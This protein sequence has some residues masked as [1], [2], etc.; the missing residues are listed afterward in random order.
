VGIGAAMKEQ[1]TEMKQ[2]THIDQPVGLQGLAYLVIIVIL[3]HAAA[4]LMNQPAAYWQ[5]PNYANDFPFSFLLHAG[6]LV[7]LILVFVYLLLIW[8]WLGR[9]NSVMALAAS[10][11]LL[12]IHLVGFSKVTM[13]GFYPIYEV[14]GTTGC[15]AFRYI[16]LVI[17]AIMLGLVLLGG[18][19]PKPI[20]TWVKR[21]LP[22]LAVIWVLLMGYGVF[23]AAFPPVSPWQP[24][25][26]A[27]SPGPRSM[28][29]IAYDTK[30]NRAVLF[31][32][33]ATWNGKE[34][35]YDASTWEWDGNDW[36]EIKT[37]VAPAGRILHAMA[38]DEKL[39]KVILYGGQ[40][41]S[42][43]LADLWEWDGTTWHRLCPV[44]NPAAR[45]GHKMIYDTQRGRIIVYG[46]QD[47][48]VGFPEAWTWDGQ[49]WTYFQFSAS[50]PGVYNAPLIYD[51]AGER[52]I[53][54]MGGGWG[55]TWIWQG[56]LW[57]K[58]N[59]TVQPP[60]R[61]EATLVYDPVNNAT[62]LFGGTNDNEY[63]YD[64]T[65]IFHQ[66]T[67]TQVHALF[68]PPERNKAIAFYDPVRKSMILYGGEI[69]GS[70]YSDMWEL[71]LPQ[72]EQ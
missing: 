3:T 5:N 52:T 4:L 70:I 20:V 41:A 67:W 61:D 7:Y 25:F 33:L 54:F 49:S 57:R 26:P 15:Y 35:V 13:C 42:G 11:S 31:G 16:P 47:G 51:L 24:L 48:K 34:W 21:V 62:I 36:Q 60:T 32:G 58:P 53:S 68:S 37:S 72:G 63:L 29:A 19:L 38:Y 71:M 22:S 40:N 9:L 69:N 28:S 12:L 18:R 14:H 55:G 6:P 56:D 44:C 39:G 27:H 45:F 17:E 65:W 23:R 59:L 30:R 50:S 46:G 43:N 64:D 8:W 1:P 66:D 2:S 10:T